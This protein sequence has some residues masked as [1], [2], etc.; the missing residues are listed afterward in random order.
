MGL[1]VWVYK[2]LIKNPH[3]SQNMS[4]KE[5][6]KLIKLINSTPNK[7]EGYVH[8]NHR[9]RNEKIDKKSKGIKKELINKVL[10]KETDN[11]YKKVER[12]KRSGKSL[13]I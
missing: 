12:I 3:K 13:K 1:K 4:K 9:T 8:R 10:E 5:E 6:R 2:L 11:I 7:F